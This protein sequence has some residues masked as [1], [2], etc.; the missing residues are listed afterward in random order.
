MDVELVV[1]VVEA[2]DNE[3]IF[4]VFFDFLELVEES[5]I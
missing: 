1:V 5:F 4:W 2:F 3:E